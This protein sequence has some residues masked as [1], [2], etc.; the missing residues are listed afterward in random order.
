M[1]KYGVISG[2]YFLVYRRLNTG[3][4]GPGK[5][6]HLSTF[7]A[8][9]GSQIT[10]AL[11]KITKKPPKNL[12]KTANYDTFIISYDKQLLQNHIKFILQMTAAKISQNYRWLFQIAFI[13]ITNYG[14]F[15]SYYIL[16]QKLLQITAGITNFDVIVNCVLIKGLRIRM[17]EKRKWNNRLKHQ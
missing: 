1:S 17:E 15:Q 13:F 3:K 7:H 6:L 12:R 5:T 9:M 8:V 16:R 4:Y 11:L 10:A 2:P 14:N